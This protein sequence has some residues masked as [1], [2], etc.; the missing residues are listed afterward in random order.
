MRPKAIRF[1]RLTK[2]TDITKHVRQEVLVRDN[3]KCI[4][5]GSMYGLS[6][7]HFVPRSKCGMGIS[8]NLVTLCRHCHFKVHNNSKLNFQSRIKIYLDTL[9]PGFKKTDRIHNKYRR[10]L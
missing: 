9:Y 8:E 6:L 4:I 10:V 1:N 2:A 3:A 7:H 5:C